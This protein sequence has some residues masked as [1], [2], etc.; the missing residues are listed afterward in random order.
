MPPLAPDCDLI[1][2]GL[3]PQIISPATNTP[4]LLR[5]D[6]PFKFQKISLKA[7]A[8]SDSGI[9][10]WFLDGRLVGEGTPDKKLFTEVGMGKHRISVSDE[11]GRSDSV[12]FEVR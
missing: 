12:K 5:K 3:A 4:Y 6:T 2:A 10:H 1:P 9:L 8:G 11:I 7:E